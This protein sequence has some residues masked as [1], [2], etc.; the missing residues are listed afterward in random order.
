M[1]TVL[2]FLLQEIPQ[3][4]FI[5]DNLRKSLPDLLPKFDIIHIC[6]KNNYD[7]QVK[8][9]GYFQVEYLYD[10]ESAFSI[11]S[12]CVSRAGSNTIFELLHSKIPCLLIPLPKGNSRGDQVLNAEYFQKKGL[13]NVLPQKVLSPQSLVLAINSVYA[14]RFNIIRNYERMPITDASRQISRII[15]DSYN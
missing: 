12:I 2:S 4:R 14:N 3:I 15:A 6:G 11:A 1:F 5:N 9:N 10:I 13:V 7:K 8:F